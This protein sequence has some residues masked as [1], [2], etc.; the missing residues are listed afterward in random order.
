MPAHRECYNTEEVKLHLVYLC[1]VCLTAE[2]KEPMQEERV[3]PRKID[4]EKEEPDTEVSESDSSQDK[5]DSEKEYQDTTD[6]EGIRF[7]AGWMVK[8]KKKRRSKSPKIDKKETVCPLLIDGKCP[9][10]ISGKKCEYKHKNICFKYCAFGTKE[11]HRG[12]C[13]FGDGCRYLHP[14]L[15]KNSVSIRMCLN[16]SCTNVHLRYTKRTKQSGGREKSGYR[17][18]MNQRETKYGDDYSRD[19]EQNKPRTGNYRREDQQNRYRSNTGRDE[20]QS[21]QQHFLS[22]MVEK[23]QLQLSNQIQKEIRK[24]FQHLQ[25]QNAQEMEDYN[26]EYPNMQDPM[27]PSWNQSHHQW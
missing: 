24:Q 7:D 16:E 23:M 20:N 8:K 25:P 12:G 15:C 1:Q 4:A 18:P 2:K 22:Q 26:A 10:G 6:N 14:T 27:N 3:V 11:M 21:S 13:R 9:H 19:Y 5:E 17:K